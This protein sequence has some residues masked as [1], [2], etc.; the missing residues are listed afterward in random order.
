MEAKKAK[1][2]KQTIEALAWLFRLAGEA[3]DEKAVQ[4]WDL[5][6]DRFMAAYPKQV[7]P[8]AWYCKGAVARQRGQSL[9]AQR[10][11]HRYLRE[12]RQESPPSEESIARGLLMLAVIL[13]TRNRLKR[14]RWLAN[15]VLKRYESKTIRGIN[16]LVYLLLGTLDERE[17]NYSGALHWFQKSHAEFLG[18]HNW[19]YHLYVLYGYARIARYQRNYSQAYWYLDLLDKAASGT[20]FLLIRR[21]VQLE[22]SRLEQDAVDL[23]IDSRK[24]IVKIRESGPVSLGNQHVLIHILEALSKAHDKTGTDRERGLTKAEIIEHVWQEKYNPAVHD[25]KLYYNINRL[26][27]LIEP[28]VRKPQYLLNSREGYRLAPSL[29]VHFIGDYYAE[30]QGG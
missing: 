28:N 4:K 2:L 6:L 5:E 11:F 20:E 22:R 14:S 12:V 19:Y 7:P 29:K 27:K 15:E 30:R 10:W 16:G 9:L 8:M 1:N 25:N 3:L 18:D 13:Q 23:L 21:E 26:R 17:K 24:G